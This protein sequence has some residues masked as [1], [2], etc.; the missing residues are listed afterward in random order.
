MKV[1]IANPISIALVSFLAVMLIPDE[2]DGAALRLNL[3]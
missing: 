2:R 1:R 3:W